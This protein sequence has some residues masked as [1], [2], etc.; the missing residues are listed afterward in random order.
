MPT[1]RPK[2]SIG[3]LRGDILEIEATRTLSDAARAKT[4][5]WAVRCTSVKWCT[6]ALLE[7]MLCTRKSYSPMKAISY[8]AWWLDKHGWYG[9]R[10]KVEIPEKTESAYAIVGCYSVAHFLWGFQVPECRRH[11]AEYC[12]K[13]PG[14]GQTMALGRDRHEQRPQPRS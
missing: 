11:R 10:P 3:L 12:T 14:E 2:V 5:P 6:C 4:S 8:F 13:D 7:L 9:R 1:K